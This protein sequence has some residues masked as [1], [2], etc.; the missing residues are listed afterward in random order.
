MIDILCFHGC[1]QEKYI[2]SS[3]LKNLQNN[4]KLCNW[5][6][7]EGKFS[8]KDGGFGWYK[9]KDTDHTE[10]VSSCYFDILKHIKIPSNTILLGFSEGGQFVLDI[11][12]TLPNI[13]GVIALSPSYSVSI[14]KTNINCPVIFIYSNIEDKYIKKK[15]I[16][17]EKT[18]NR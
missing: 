14:P 18:N 7:L 4:L 12:Q 1:G 3:L 17:M 16:H 11:A 13:K 8:K 15:C 6:F 10:I 2:F 5:K 9:Y